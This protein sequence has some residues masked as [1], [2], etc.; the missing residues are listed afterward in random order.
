M[1]PAGQ[2][3]KVN[4]PA[5]GVI[6]D[7]RPQG[8]SPVAKGDEPKREQ[9]PLEGSWEASQPSH[10]E[11]RT[12][13]ERPADDQPQRTPDLPRAQVKLVIPE[14][15]LSSSEDDGLGYGVT[16]AGDFFCPGCKAVMAINQ[17]VCLNCGFHL[18][19]G[20]KVRRRHKEIRQSWDEGLPRKTR[21]VLSVILS[22]GF[23]LAGIA[24][25]ETGHTGPIG[26]FI[27]VLIASSQVLYLLGTHGQLELVRN[28]KGRITLTRKYWIAFA[29]MKSETVAVDGHD[30]LKLIQTAQAGTIEYIIGIILLIPFVFPAICWY[31]AVIQGTTFEVALTKDMG[32]SVRTLFKSREEAKAREIA[33]LLNQISKLPLNRR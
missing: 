9:N 30:G 28:S 3:P 29:P 6:T 33:E 4:C 1:T 32:R 2:K 23:V 17:V 22:I 10:P 13:V 20:N 11:A 5:C 24:T 26:A 15:Y 8:F 16:G 18:E 27:M 7:L 25:S 21:M 19:K 14:D 31:L 12:Q